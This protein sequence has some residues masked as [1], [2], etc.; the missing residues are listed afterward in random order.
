MKSRMTLLAL[1]TGSLHVCAMAQCDFGAGNSGQQQADPPAPDSSVIPDAALMKYAYGE[2]PFY[3]RVRSYARNLN[4]AFERKINVLQAQEMNALGVSRDD[5]EQIY[6]HLQSFCD[7][8]G[9]SWG[10]VLKEKCQEA[11]RR[12]PGDEEARAFVLEL[13][14][15]EADLNKLAEESMAAIA[16]DLGEEVRSKVE[17]RITDEGESIVFTKVDLGKQIEMSGGKFSAYI[18]SQCEVL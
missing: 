11:G 12:S 6:V 8:Q 14:N 17:A 15:R 13:D 3:V 7:K 18:D 10:K 5:L 4:R 2:A 16:D 9:E 1:V